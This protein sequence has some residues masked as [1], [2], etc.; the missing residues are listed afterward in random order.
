VS[1]ARARLLAALLITLWP[2]AVTR[3]PDALL[4]EGHGVVLGRWSLATALG[5]AAYLLVGLLL[6]AR[7]RAG[8]DR[9]RRRRA[10][11]A[12][13]GL[14][15]GVAAGVGLLEA[16]LR[17][18][19]DLLPRG[20]ARRLAGPAAP[21]RL[22]EPRFCAYDGPWGY[23]G[24]PGL[25]LPPLP[26]APELVREGKVRPHPLAEPGEEVAIR[27]DDRGLRARAG[28][29]GPVE[30]V[31]VGD[32]F[33]FGWNLPPDAAWPARLEA[34]LAAP[35]DAVAFN[36]W[37]PSQAGAAF[38]AFGAPQ[39]PGAVVWTFY[40]GNDLSEE[41]AWRAWQAEGAPPRD[42]A[43]APPPALEGSRAAALLGWLAD[44]LPLWAWRRP[45]SPRPAQVA[46]VGGRRQCFAFA[47]GTLRALGSDPRA[48][49]AHAALDPALD[50]IA[51]GR[52][53]AGDD[54]RFVCLL[55]PSKAHVLYPLL[56]EA[57]RLA[58]LEATFGAEL[59][60]ARAR[61]APDRYRAQLRDLDHTIRAR[62]SALLD[63]VAAGLAA[64]GVEVLDLRPV[65]RAAYAAGR[66]PYFALDSHWSRA[67][68]EVVAEA[69]AE[70]VRGAR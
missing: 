25:E 15:L 4:A 42:P 59:A 56:P 28:L 16:T 9:R 40:E 30:V 47:A 66:P 33:T 70:W 52:D 58:A 26:T 17:L 8:R 54:A 61:L 67:G 36:A 60:P 29:P 55:I 22:S 37:G 44:G 45:G 7:R 31:A 65:L 39:E 48:W 62:A 43:A 63:R 68:H 34:A 23:R 18:A 6:L 69:V 35:V 27:Y 57:D 32:S 3:S 20:A 13:G 41:A 49:E 51:A 12:A 11:F 64:R 1:P 10:A 38:A 14:A 5:F 50:A 46:R 2:L 53:R 21:F 19:P 24:R